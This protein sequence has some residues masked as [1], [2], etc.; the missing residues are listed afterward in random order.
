MRLFMFSSQSRTH[1]HAFGGDQEGSKLPQKFGPWGLTG[2]IGPRATPPHRFSRLS[3][4]QAIGK[5]G[6]QLWRTREKE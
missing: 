1:L 3:I 2:M 5:V 6:F 4:E